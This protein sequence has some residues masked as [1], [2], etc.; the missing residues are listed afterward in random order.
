MTT[1]RIGGCS[2][3]ARIHASCNVLV[4]VVIKCSLSWNWILSGVCMKYCS[5]HNRCLA[6]LF[7]E[8]FHVGIWSHLSATDFS[9]SRSKTENLGS[10]EY[11]D[12]L[13]SA[14]QDES[15]QSTSTVQDDFMLIRRLS[16]QALTLQEQ[17]LTL[18]EQAIMQRKRAL[19]LQEQAV[20][21]R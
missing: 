14:V 19:T 1:G 17:A 7:K 10:R 4:S 15:G 11:M 21:Q 2:L 8:R 3:T 16:E 12:L 9:S 13:E 18:Q 20:M 6:F 5:Q